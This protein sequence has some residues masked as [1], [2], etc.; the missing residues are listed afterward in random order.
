MSNVRLP[1]E[2]IQNGNKI[3]KICVEDVYKIMNRIIDGI[4]KAYNNSIDII[5]SIDKEY[6][7]NKGDTKY[8][9][10][11]IIGRGV[12]Q[13]CLTDAFDEEIGNDIAFMKAKLN[14]NIKKHNVLTRI[15]NEFSKLLDTID[16]DLNKID[17]Y[18]CDDL[19]R[20]RQYNSDYLKDIEF[21][22]GIDD[23]KEII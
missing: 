1:I 18:I 7:P 4:D 23:E 17:N 22:L 11:L 12:S 9:G 21:K 14:A 16:L 2:T 5:D 15:W 3:T 13:P 20:L 8:S 6:I 19:S 10:S